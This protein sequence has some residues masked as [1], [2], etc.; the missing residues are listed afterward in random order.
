[1][2]SDE[3]NARFGR[4]LRNYREKK[5]LTQEQVAELSGIS[6]TS[7]KTME[8]GKTGTKFKTLV[9]IAEALD[10]DL[11]A[12]ITD[13]DEDAA[14]VNVISIL[15]NRPKSIILTAEDILERL[16]YLYEAQSGCDD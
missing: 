8:H 10:V 9:K 2:T 12:L 14:L 5:R 3:L 15:K 4:N 11:A 6:E 16:I 13:A 1:M 7:Y